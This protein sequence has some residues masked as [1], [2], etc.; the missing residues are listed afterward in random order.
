MS[1]PGPGPL[2]CVW[3]LVIRL[4]IGLG[5]GRG[6]DESIPPAEVEFVSLLLVRLDAGPGTEPG[7]GPITAPDPKPSLSHCVIGLVIGFIESWCRSELQLTICW[8]ILVSLV[9][10]E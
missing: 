6:R 8:V 3:L 7:V 2:A 10:L 9:I 4:G 5:L 1:V